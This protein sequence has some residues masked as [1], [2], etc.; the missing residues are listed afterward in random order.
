M[1]MLTIG[2]VLQG[3]GGGGLMTLSQ[4]LIGETIPPRER[5]HYQGYLA[6]VAV[7]ANGLGPILGGYLT[8]HFGWSSVFLI[9]VPVGLLAFLLVL[10]LE[11]RPPA[12]G[13]RTFDLPGL[14]LFILFLL[15]ALLA[16]DQVRHFSP[17]A[18]PLGLSLAALSLIGLG[19]LLWRE[20]RA[21]L[22]LLPLSL[23][24]QPSVWRS[25]GLAACHGAALVA[26]IAFLPIYLQVVRGATPAQTGLLFLPLTVGIGLGSMII[27]RV[28]GRTGRTAIFPTVG[29]VLVTASLVFL[30]LF[31]PRLS[32]MQLGAVFLWIGLFMG[33]VMGVVQ[34]TVQS[35]AGPTT[36]GAAAASVQFSR[37]VGAA[38]GTAIVAAVLFSILAAKS[39][40]TARL[41]ALMVEQGPATLASLT[42]AQ[43]ANLQ[44]EIGTAFR[45]AFL[46]IA[47][48]TFTGF[49]LAV[50]MPLR[51]I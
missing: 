9:N 20:R 25:D 23:M 38:V 30:A 51:R 18:L 49:L 16:L 11:T 7:T 14:L 41:F 3:L 39:A 33:T 13:A 12:E 36:L 24:R 28:V 19:L 42:P 27:G 22:P 50:T 48:F 44:V 29:L 17:R 31:A 43:Q 37:S 35:A 47:L 21:A 6:G 10:R 8:Q 1:T 2:R 32:S 4:A 5:A 34:V 15:P 46:T 45:A 26:L 40:E